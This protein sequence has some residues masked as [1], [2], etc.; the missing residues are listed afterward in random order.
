[1]AAVNNMKDITIIL[2][3]ELP[4]LLHLRVNM[5]DNDELTEYEKGEC[6]HKSSF[7]FL[8]TRIS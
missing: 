2:R 6:S 3:N 5:T 7:H 4:S 8:Q 1:M